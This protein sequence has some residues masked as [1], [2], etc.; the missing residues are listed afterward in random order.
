MSMSKPGLWL[1][2]P[3]KRHKDVR[4]ICDKS[5]FEDRDI[6]QAR[7]L[8]VLERIC[9]SGRGIVKFRARREAPKVCW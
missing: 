9:H 8:D 6:S 7:Q 3:V 1:V 5:L 4:Q 2:D